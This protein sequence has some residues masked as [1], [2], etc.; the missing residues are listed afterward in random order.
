[1]KKSH[2]VETSYPANFPEERITKARKAVKSKFGLSF[3]YVYISK[4]TQPVMNAEQSKFDLNFAN[5]PEKES[6][7]KHKV[8]LKQEHVDRRTLQLEMQVMKR[9][10]KYQLRKNQRESLL[11]KKRLQRITMPFLINKWN[12]KITFHLDPKERRCLRAGQ[13]NWKIK[14]SKKLSTR[15]DATSELN[16]GGH[17]SR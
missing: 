8:Q 11:C 12:G 16:I 10:T 6:F 15:F 5:G 13:N 4:C 7:L 3:T 14:T 2:A 1:M 17:L 9:K